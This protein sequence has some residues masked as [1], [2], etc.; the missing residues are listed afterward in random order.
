MEAS[1]PI[2]APAVH[3]NSDEYHEGHVHLEDDYPEKVKRHV[4][5]P[6][7]EFFEISV[8]NWL[9]FIIGGIFAL[10]TILLSEESK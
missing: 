2:E 10:T 9:A 5:D 6:F 4:E 1:T 8:L 7:V 3:D